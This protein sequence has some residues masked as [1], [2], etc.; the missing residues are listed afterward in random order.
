MTTSAVYDG[1]EHLATSYDVPTGSLLQR[2]QFFAIYQNQE[3]LPSNSLLKSYYMKLDLNT[4]ASRN[5]FKDLVVRNENSNYAYLGNM[6]MSIGHVTNSMIFLLINIVSIL[7]F[8]LTTFALFFYTSTLYKHK[9]LFSDWLPEQQFVVFYLIVMLLHQNPFHAIGDWQKARSGLALTVYVINYLA[10]AGLCTVMLLFSGISSNMKD[11]PLSFYGPKVLVGVTIFCISM[12]ML[13]YQFPSYTIGNTRSSMDSIH[14]WKDEDKSTYIGVSITLLV[15]YWL[16]IVHWF[17]RMYFTYSELLNLPY[18]RTR[19]QQLV[20]RFYLLQGSL[21]LIY[22]VLQYSIAAWYLLFT[23]N[24]RS[25]EDD[26]AVI[27]AIMRFNV[28]IIGKTIFVSMFGFILAFVTLPADYLMD[29]QDKQYLTNAYAISESEANEIID[30]RKRQLY[31]EG[32]KHGVRDL[33]TGAVNTVKDIGN[34]FV[35]GVLA[36]KHRSI[37]CLETATALLDVASIVYY[38]F[39]GEGKDDELNDDELKEAMN[40]NLAMN[41]QSKFE[42]VEV[43]SNRAL[44]LR[45]IV[46]RHMDNDSL[47]V[48]FRGTVNMDNMYHNFKY[49][50][51]D[52]DFSTMEMPNIDEQDGLE[53]W[54]AEESNSGK[55][56]GKG[57][58]DSSRDTTGGGLLRDIGY[59]LN[60]GFKATTDLLSSMGNTAKNSVVATVDFTQNIAT[61]TKEQITMII[62]D[63]SESLVNITQGIRDS[64]TDVSERLSFRA[65]TTSGSRRNSWNSMDDD[66]GSQEGWRGSIDNLA[67]TSKY[68]GGA[69]SVKALKKATKMKADN[70][71]M[72]RVDENTN[73]GD[74]ES[75]DVPPMRNQTQSHSYKRSVKHST[76]SKSIK[77]SDRHH[78]DS[79]TNTDS[80]STKGTNDSVSTRSSRKEHRAS[81][82]HLPDLNLLHIIHPRA[83]E[84]FFEYYMAL[85]ESVHQVLRRELKK[86][87]AKIYFTGHSLGGA[88]ATLC[89]YDVNV[90]TVPRVKTYL[91]H[92]KD[93]L[94]ENQIDSLLETSLY[95]FGSPRVGDGVF[96]NK[97]H[98]L[99]THSYRIVGDGDVVTSVPKSWNGFKH[100]DTLVL[101]DNSGVGSIIVDPSPVEKL[102]RARKVY[103]S[104]NTHM[105]SQYKEGLEAITKLSKLLRAERESEREKEREAKRER[106]AE[107]ARRS[108]STIGMR[109]GSMISRSTLS[110]HKRDVS[111][112]GARSDNKTEN[113]S[114]VGSVGNIGQIEG[115][116]IP[117]RGR[118]S[119]VTVENPMM[120]SLRD[121]FIE[122]T[123][124]NTPRVSEANAED[125]DEST[126]NSVISGI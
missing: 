23:F 57:D 60:T 35:G 49:A 113:I 38:G 97:F 28:L 110:S 12:V 11:N 42:V 115:D 74:I 79:I 3:S 83:H 119:S 29:E 102:F 108:K 91:Q 47:V 75:A 111:I 69:D 25:E 62:A 46:A 54:E 52:A 50:R 82:G 17:V 124:A 10:Q 86:K 98:N 9:E 109:L 7:L 81:L 107:L 30:G 64:V 96:F 118:D 31:N 90:N 106:K 16:W 105:I 36:H 101:I 125:R 2:F 18:L 33:L 67:T 61:T 77:K 5:F 88:M 8:I 73:G 78:S 22:F 72:P 34:L 6:E 14:D 104:V 41:M 100:V 40:T 122:M 92:K 123:S 65:S 94:S 51:V 26:A 13:S 71:K 121:T 120:G 4:D 21:I 37:F 93:A 43:I 89:C 20:F 56:S 48:A 80:I 85:R 112:R 99:C 95:T 55:T 58:E 53:E 15:L 84:G 117:V 1:D 44:A 27:S 32:E 103:T 70:N 39:E 116:D 126:W 45:C 87:A 19:Y 59:G 68:R 114:S 76:Y 24:F 66:E 63:T